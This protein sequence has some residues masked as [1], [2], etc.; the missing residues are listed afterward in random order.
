MSGVDMTE[1]LGHF[2][3][4]AVLL[5]TFERLTRLLDGR[6]RV[7]LLIE[8]AKFYLDHEALV[9]RVDNYC[10]C[11]PKMNGFIALATQQ[12]EDITEAAIGRAI[13]SQFAT[14][15]LFPQETINEAAYRDLA[16]TDAEIRALAE[17][18]P[19]LPGRHVLLKRESGS[20]ILD[21]DMHDMADE[22]AVLSSRTKTVELL[23]GIR[24]RVG[25]EPREWMPVFLRERHT[26]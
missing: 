19:A 22:I 2:A 7:A 6:K 18:L 4:P 17:T 9:E 12:P 21:I 1:F 3:L 24:A 11:F 16:C 23:D 15:F 5:Y 10:R 20:V 13:I 14:K 8:E 26:I 25:D